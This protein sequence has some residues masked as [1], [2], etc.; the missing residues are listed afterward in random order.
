MFGPLGEMDAFTW[1]TAVAQAVL[2]AG[3]RDEG[4]FPSERIHWFRRLTL[5]ARQLRGLVVQSSPPSKKRGKGEGRRKSAES[6]A[7]GGEGEGSA[8]NVDVDKATN[9]GAGDGPSSSPAEAFVTRWV[10]VTDKRILHA[11]EEPTWGADKEKVKTLDLARFGVAFSPWSPVVGGV[12]VLWDAPLSSVV[13]LALEPAHEGIRVALS[14]PVEYSADHQELPLFSYSQ[15]GGVSARP[16]AVVC[17]PDSMSELAILACLQGSLGPEFAQIHLVRPHKYS[18]CV[19]GHLMRVH[20]TGLLTTP[21]RHWYAVANGI[22]YEYTPRKDALPDGSNTPPVSSRGKKG[23]KG[24]GAGTAARNSGYP[25]T[26]TM[27]LPL[28]GVSIQTGKIEGNENGLK[29]CRAPRPGGRSRS[30]GS[31]PVVS[32]S[33]RVA[34]VLEEKTVDEVLLQADSHASLREWVNWLTSQSSSPSA[35]SKHGGADNKGREDLLQR[36]P[37]RGV[38][39]GCE[40]L[41]ADEAQTLCD[42]LW[43]AVFSRLDKA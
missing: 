20:T 16:N 13:S 10:I 25:Y 28:S 18:I 1:E 37:Y 17:D 9:A 35:A 31:L 4:D 8:S 26:L 43:A 41:E 21:E 15:L 2:R 38:F 34:S 12:R 36:H 23:G 24:G 14:T 5:R 42:E 11:Q 32:A 29:I 22:L 3:M 6:A 40:S 33:A 7:M 30:A 39:I 19:Q 27:V